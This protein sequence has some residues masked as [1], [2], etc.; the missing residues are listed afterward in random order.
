MTLAGGTRRLAGARGPLAVVVLPILIAVLSSSASPVLQ[1]SASPA[2]QSSSAPSRPNLIVVVTDD[3]AAWGVGAYANPDVRTPAMDRLAAEGVR[4][5]N[6]FTPTPV[7]SP[8]RVTLL[9]GHYGTEVGITDWISPAEADA[10]LGLRP[11]TVTWPEVLQQAG[12]RT[13]LV[14][15]WHLGSRPEYHPTRHGYGW[16][17]G[18]LAG[19]TTP[20]DPR[21]E[22]DGVETDLLGPT[23]DVLTDAA[24]G[25]IERQRD[26]PF[27]LSLH[28]R[29]PHTPYGPV[30]ALDA[31]PFAELVPIVPTFPGL[32]VPQ[33]QRLTREYYASIHSVDRNLGRL[34][35]R[36]EALGLA[37]RTVIV[38]TSDHGYNIGQHGLH[39]KGN[40]YWIVGGVN[41]PTVPNM[42]DTSIRA[43]FIVR[44][45]GIPSGRVVEAPVTFED[46]APT[47]VA[48]GGAAWPSDAA[49]H[50]RNLG[51]WL[52]GES[53]T[54]WRDT[55]FG[56]YDIHH[57]TIAHLRMIRTADW[58]LVRSY[59][60]TTK[61]QLFDLRSDPGELTN[62][63]NRP[64]HRDTRRQLESRLREWMRAI[65]DPVH[66]REGL[67]FAPAS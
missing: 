64:A 30:P 22:V 44:G 11:D 28:Y 14:G 4:F 24:I 8:S 61:D 21:L 34:L 15:K 51:P 13:G 59:G 6:A 65:G 29:A 9:T 5:A 23:P 39:S 46:L 16:F 35:D 52:R 43:P 36:V 27:A 58:K 67:L 41:G 49:G 40:G 26:V 48:L 53:P 12:Y 31:R 37:Q 10:G 62:L 33:V 17:F 47:L 63:W 18:F 25:F 57:Y 54:E 50:G 42:F 7:C 32:D 55:V 66:S 56:Q 3:Q 60:T 45:P 20:M 1:S 2:L 38:F 19:G